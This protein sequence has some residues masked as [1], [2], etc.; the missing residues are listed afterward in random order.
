MAS[1]C[2]A[3][4]HKGI[5]PALVSGQATRHCLSCGGYIVKYKSLGK[6]WVDKERFWPTFTRSVEKRTGRCHFCNGNL[7][8]GDQNCPSCGY[9]LPLSCG[10][11]GERMISTTLAGLKVDF[12]PLCR[13]VWLDGDEMA[14]LASI[15]NWSV[16][17][18]TGTPPPEA[19]KVLKSFNRMSKVE[20]VMNA[21]LS[22]FEGLFR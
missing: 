21:I 3:C 9:N 11:H 6:I 13:D 12:C 22:P 16:W 5:I 7:E 18:G 2:P 20:E 14:E 8:Y 4:Q 19:E 10:T 1:L 17:N 15:N